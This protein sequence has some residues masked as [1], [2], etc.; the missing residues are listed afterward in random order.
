MR[1]DPIDPAQFVEH[2]KHLKARLKPNSISVFLSND[3]MP[4]SADGRLIFVQHSDL[5]YLCGIDQEETILVIYPDA[6]EEKHRE[7]LFVRET[8]ELIA[9]WEGPKYTQA[10]ASAISGIQTVYWNREFDAVFRTLAIESE[11]I[12]LNTNEH[13]RAEVVVETREVRFLKGCMANYPLHYY[14][15]LAP[16][17]HALRAVK[18]R[19]ETDLIQKACHITEK[20]FR[21]L[22]SFIRPGVWE[23]EVEAE[24]IHEFLMNRSR[25]P[26]YP[27]IIA[28]GASTCILHYENNDRQCQNGDLLLMDFGAEFAGYASDLTR[29]VPVNGRFSPRQKAVY[30]AALRVKRAAIAMLIPGNT[31]AEYYKAVGLVMEKELVELGLL[32][33]TD[34]HS[35]PVN[36]PAYKKYFMHG[37]SHHLGLNV[38]DYGNRYRIFEPGMVFTVEPG[39]YIRE[40]GLGVRIENDIVITAD[41]PVDLMKDIPVE[42]EEIEMLMAG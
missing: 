33:L 6:Q 16:I 40:E 20:A 23:F 32:T 34:I 3:V 26:A 35:Q 21:R 2:R 4:T 8:S 1:Y 28:S 42:I 41:G 22:L 12:Y 30:N 19:M 5:F 38:H 17:M 25:G 29:T 15:R 13:L 27:S 7:I 10:Q 14:E 36:T 18:S 31:L 9:I 24:I 39:I 37:T 11:T